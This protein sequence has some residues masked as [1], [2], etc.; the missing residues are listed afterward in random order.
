MTS[1]Y[2]HTSMHAYH[3]TYIHIIW[4]P[5]SSSLPHPT[6]PVPFLSPS[7]TTDWMKKRRRKTGERKG[8]EKGYT[9]VSSMLNKTPGRQDRNE[10]TF[11]GKTKR[12]IERK[13]KGG[14][15]GREKTTLKCNQRPAD[16][17]TW[18]LEKFLDSAKFSVVTVQSGQ[19]LCAQCLGQY[20]HSDRT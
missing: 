14:W 11:K 8:K 6:P 16:G 2:I 19:C 1:I 18:K 9:P 7:P 3:S 5:L 12:E 20:G 13:R 15:E 17:I 10:N 4:T